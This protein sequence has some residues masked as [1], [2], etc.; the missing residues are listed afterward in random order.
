MMF[1]KLMLFASMA[2][3]VFLVV[4]AMAAAL[5]NAETE[6]WAAPNTEIPLEGE[7]SF[8]GPYGGFQGCT[9]L[10][11]AIVNEDSSTATIPDG[12]LKFAPN[13]CEGTQYFTGCSMEYGAVSGDSQTDFNGISNPNG[14][15]IDMETDQSCGQYAPWGPG[16]IAGADIA[17]S[18]PLVLSRKAGDNSLDNM[19]IPKTVCNYVAPELGGF[20][21]KVNV[22]GNLHA[23]D[24]IPW[25]T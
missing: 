19:T 2:A 12:S 6:E 10:A 4:P 18:S 17:C 22:Q 15:Y 24:G 13:S 23:V 5:E 16:A 3:A 14:I 7:F 21:W 8:V 20:L 25:R 1:R 11:S 9:L